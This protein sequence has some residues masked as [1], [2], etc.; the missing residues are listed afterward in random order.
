MGGTYE[1]YL[2]CQ[3]DTPIENAPITMTCRFVC[4][5]VSLLLIDVGE[6]GNC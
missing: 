6:P 3:T 1:S 2:V 4:G 5:A